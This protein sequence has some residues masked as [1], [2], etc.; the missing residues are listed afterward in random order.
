MNVDAHCL[1]NIQH[2]AQRNQQPKERNQITQ[3]KFSVNM[4]FVDLID[5]LGGLDSVNYS[6]VSKTLYSGNQGG[7]RKESLDR[8]L[9]ECPSLSYRPST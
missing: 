5:D 8:S 7:L 4:D 9:P 1:T 3:L 2:F 6:V